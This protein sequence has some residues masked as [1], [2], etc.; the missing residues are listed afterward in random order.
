MGLFRVTAGY[1]WGIP[2]PGKNPRA[3]A[4]PREINGRLRK[5]NRDRN[6]R[7]SSRSGTEK[8]LIGGPGFLAGSHGGNL[9]V[10]AD[11]G[12]FG[13]GPFGRVRR[14]KFWRCRNAALRKRA[15]RLSGSGRWFQGPLRV[16]GRCSGRRMD[17]FGVQARLDGGFRGRNA[18]AGAA[19]PAVISGSGG[20]GRCPVRS[21]IGS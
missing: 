4:L 7:F 14:R 5:G 15:R 21:V 16:L 8:L 17:A 10:Y 3:R 2:G 12:Q 18:V 1:G 9:R 20:H 11:G 13:E 6:C 19:G